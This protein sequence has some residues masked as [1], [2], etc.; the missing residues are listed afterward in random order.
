MISALVVALGLAL[1]VVG[2]ASGGSQ[3]AS[4]MPG[5]PSAPQSG[6]STTQTTP[7]STD[8]VMPGGPV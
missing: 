4:V 5:G 7:P 3:P 8:S 1:S 2:G 6:A